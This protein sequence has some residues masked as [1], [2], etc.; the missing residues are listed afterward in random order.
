MAIPSMRN[1]VVGSGTFSAAANGT[2][3][4][5]FSQAQDFKVGTTIGVSG[6]P[7][8]ACT[9]KYGSG[10]RWVTS[11]LWG[12][13]T[14]AAFYRADTSNA[15]AR[16]GTNTWLP[17]DSPVFTYISRADNNGNPDFYLYQDSLFPE[18]GVHPYTKDQWTGRVRWTSDGNKTNTAPVYL[19][20][21]PTRLRVHEGR[22][23]ALDANPPLADSLISDPWSQY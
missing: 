18:N 4:L 22:L 16:G 19:I 2:H 1:L 3:Q 21:A 7:N 11:A 20:D 15:R 23:N 9:I 13:G 12:F 8:Y 5:T 14:G 10:T 17:N 6:A